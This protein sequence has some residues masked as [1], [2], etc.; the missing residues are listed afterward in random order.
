MC[1]NLILSFS[2]VFSDEAGF[3]LELRL[4]PTDKLRRWLKILAAEQCK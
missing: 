2:E 3:E 1:G 4:I